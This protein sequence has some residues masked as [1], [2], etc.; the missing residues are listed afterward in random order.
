MALLC[1]PPAVAAND[2]AARNTREGSGR[3]TGD[4]TPSNELVVRVMDERV[5]VLRG[6]TAALA[7]AAAATALGHCAA[8]VGLSLVL[9]PV[10]DNDESESGSESD[11]DG[12]AGE[13]REGR[14]GSSASAVDLEDPDDPP[15]QK[16][17]RVG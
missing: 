13:A 11:L 9:E 1:E 4:P 10:A 8:H 2:P 16:K 5:T 17:R 3:E 7:A 6:A 14:G 15:E 12:S